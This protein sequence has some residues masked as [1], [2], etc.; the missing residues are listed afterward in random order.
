MDYRTTLSVKGITATMAAM[1][2]ANPASKLPDT[3][4]RI[5]AAHDIQAQREQMRL[6]L[7]AVAEMDIQSAGTKP[8]EDRRTN[9][10]A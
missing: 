1:R 2:R 4:Q 6:F 3:E 10:A 7:D 8:R 5:N 9:R